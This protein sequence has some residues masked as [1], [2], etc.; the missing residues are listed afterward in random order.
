MSFNEQFDQHGVWRREFALNLKVLAEWMRDHDLMNAAVEERLLLL[1]SQVRA[2]KVMVAFVAEFS[3]GKSELINAIFF[4][5]YGRRIMP[6][7]AGRTTMCPTELGYDADVP[8]CLRLLPIETRLEAQ[9]LMEWRKAPE[10]WVQ[11]DLDVND[12]VQLAQMMEKVAEVRYVTQDDAR[13]LGFWN[14][15]HPEDNPPVGSDGLVEVPKWRHAL[16]NIAHPLLKQGLVIL[17]TPGLNAIGA[18]P[19]L[20]VSLI[21]QAHA[22]VFILGADTGVTKSDLTI[23]REHLVPPS[24]GGDTRLVVLNKIDSLWDALST[25]EQVQAQINNQRVTS[26][27]ILGLPVSKVLA[28]SAQKGLVAKV[29]GDDALLQASQLPALEL[30]L[31]EGLMGQ[32]QKILQMAVISGI[33]ELKNEAGR[34]IHVRRRD[35]SEQ[36][37]ELRGLRGKN[38]SVIKQMRLRIEQEKAEFDA[39]GA[40]IYAVRSVHL[41]LLREV[42]TLLSTPTLKAE[43]G[44]LVTALKQPGIKL[45]LKKTYG[46][47]F[48]QLRAG[49]KSVQV[50]TGEI[51]TMLSSSFRQINS[52]F[53]FSLQ[54][55]KEPDVTRFAEDLDLI[56]RSHLQYLGMGNVLR[57]SQAAFSERLVRALGTRLRVVY[58]TA[59]SEVELWNKSA[60]SQLDAQLR[61]RRRNFARR[62]EA[63]ERIQ[64]AASGLDERIAEI[65]DQEASL[66][67]L[68][69]KLTELTQPFLGNLPPPAV[70]NG[71]AGVNAL[72]TEA[73]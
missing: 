72:L 41:K 70:A 61:E 53:N 23:W 52:E 44:E 46:D 51:Q 6:A 17:D 22:V 25:P 48:A 59:L 24:D 5:G 49:L 73:A 67:E 4:A 60:S 31:G 64:Q 20:T 28:V 14:D 47:T 16:I 57:L 1:E 38:V 37:M 68:D 32:R 35:L 3:R 9:A 58:E 26:A 34:A 43:L 30:A 12:P 29:T 15:S 11:V 69:A 7:T 10:K 63:I 18:E 33:G 45:R 21:P 19:E 62:L 54:V 55:P 71:R 2:D 50:L 39:S 27:E 56:E 13:A 66:N 65:D 42:V 8:P 40:R 36:M